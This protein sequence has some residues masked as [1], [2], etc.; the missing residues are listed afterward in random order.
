MRVAALQIRTESGHDQ[1]HFRQAVAMLEEAAA[2]QADLVVLPEC[3]LSGYH[4]DRDRFCEFAETPDG[5]TIRFFREFSG[6]HKMAM[7][8]PFVE[9]GEGCMYNAVA[10]VDRGLLLG[11]HRKSYLWGR[12]KDIFSPVL[13]AIPS[14]RPDRDASAS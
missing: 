3:W 5:D 8:V 11:I 14:L 6:R 2:D 1:Y 10:V 4:L 12:E 9:R 7:V 13:A